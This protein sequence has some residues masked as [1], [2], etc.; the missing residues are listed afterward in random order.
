MTP[1]EISDE[2]H[3]RYFH[4]LVWQSGT[5]WFGTP[6]QKCPLDLW[7]YQEIINEVRPDM[8]VECGTRHGGSAL[9]LAAMCEIV[10]NGEVMSVDVDASP[11][12]L[13]HRR[14]TYVHGS[15]IDPAIVARI[16]SVRKYR[17]D[18]RTLVILDSDHS[19]DH[20]L[21]EMEMYAPMVTVGS[22][23]IVEDGNLH[24]HP[25]L[26]EFGPGPAEAV[27]EF[28]AKTREFEVDRSREKFMLTFNPGGYLKRVAKGA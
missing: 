5:T 26:P 4:S 21:K 23:L 7:I 20:V 17:K 3:R 25:V 6:A 16:E 24:G 11:S 14:L 28:L 19:K 10:G 2:F 12:R 18:C 22:Y 9:F 15:S 1:Q 27:A 13:G 8:I